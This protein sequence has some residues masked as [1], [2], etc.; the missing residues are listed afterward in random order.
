MII[1]CVFEWDDQRYSPTTTY[2]KF[3]TKIKELR[4]DIEFNFINS[5]PLRVEATK[6]KLYFGGNS[7]Y[8]VSYMMVINQSNKKYFLISY[9]DAIKDIFEAGPLI[10]YNLSLLQ[11]LITTS[12]VVVDDVRFKPIPYLNYT[13]FSYVPNTPEIENIIETLYNLNLPKTIPD[14]P[15]FRNYPNDAFRRYI[16]QDSRFDSI[17]K[18]EHM[19]TPAD[20][21]AELNQHKINFSANGHAE[22]CHRDMEILGLGNVLL[23]TKLVTKFHNELIP[24]YHYIAVDVKDFTDHKAITDKIIDKYN[25]IKNDTALLDFIGKNGREWYVNNG[26]S[27]ANADILTKI[28]DFNKLK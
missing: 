5:V 16:L 11:E 25:E 20:Y 1:D 21:M 9:W 28:L 27:T 8:G 12:G 4:P 15:R 19:L 22:I 24:N 7:K 18:R 26:T 3:F 23:R 13:P 14:R 6:N 17:D 2:C 10:N